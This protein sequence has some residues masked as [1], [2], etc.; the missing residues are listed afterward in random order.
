L[1]PPVPAAGYSVLTHEAIVDASW[2]RDLKP[3]LLK[4]FPAATEDQLRD[5]RAYAYG[6]AI[7][8]DMGYYPFSS[9]FFSDLVH[10]TRSGDFIL[11]LIRDARDL[12]EYAFALGALA[13]YAADN[14]GHPIAVNRTVPLV[15]PKL[16]M[17]FGPD[18][19]YE[20]DP[21]A[22]LKT[23]FG[24]DVI[25]VAR[26]LYA[27]E[28]YHDFIGFKVAKPV[29]EH[30]F[31]DTY[32][33]PLPSLFGDLDL[34]LGTYRYAVSRAIPEMSK[35]AWSAKK[36]DIKT[37]ESSMT[38]RKFVYKLSRTSYHKEFDRNYELPG[39]GARFLAWLFRIIPKV[40]PFQALAFKVPPASAERLFLT[41]LEDTIRR[42]RELLAAADKDR[43]ELIN[44]NFDTGKPTH[45]GEY[46]LADE[47]YAKLLDRFKGSPDK[48][49][50]ELRTNILAFYAATDGPSSEPSRTVL[51]A[52]RSR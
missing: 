34:A 50:D 33:L 4:R 45:L 26:G 12:N 18:V 39:P 40:G 51:A 20:D 5:A 16:R 27:S 28:A 29:L 31:E 47:A 49:G 42:Y 46:R 7:I 14:L 41:S 15:Y 24:F 23:E 37:L 9:K 21:G 52:L 3:L 17:K 8:Q 25:Q 48:I 38:R 22:H 30:A 1:W 36:E 19:T 6:G 43:L 32:S 35:T 11:A 2:P 10:Y 44:E 13:H